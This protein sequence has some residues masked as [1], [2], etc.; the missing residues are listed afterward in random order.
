[1]LADWFSYSLTQALERHLPVPS[2]AAFILG[3]RKSACYLI[4]RARY[5][6]EVA[7]IAHVDK[8]G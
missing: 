1:M 7:E 3:D 4:I 2:S 6:Q 5:S 8:E